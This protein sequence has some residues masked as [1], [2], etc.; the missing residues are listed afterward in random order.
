MKK[1]SG[2]ETNKQTNIQGRILMVRELLPRSNFGEITRVLGIH[3]GIHYTEPD[4]VIFK[5]FQLF[6]QP[7]MH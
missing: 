7:G 1:S 5:K 6:F 3:L 2:H 4:G